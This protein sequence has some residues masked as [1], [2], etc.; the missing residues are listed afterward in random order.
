MG[1]T[2]F[3]MP[4]FVCV[5]FFPL[6]SKG[7]PCYHAAF[8]VLLNSGTRSEKTVNQ[9]KLK[10]SLFLLSNQN[11]NYLFTFPGVFN[12]FSLSPLVGRVCSVVMTILGVKRWTLHFS[13]Y[14]FHALIISFF[15]F[16]CYSPIG[17]IIP[18]IIFIVN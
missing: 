1:S 9:P 2:S 6:C 7:L 14:C 4:V 10:D 3:Q 15:V 17:Q 16:K 18:M 5:F 8:L 12:H 13:K 11:L